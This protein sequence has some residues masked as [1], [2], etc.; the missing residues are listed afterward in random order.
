MLDLM[1]NS[2]WTKT[3]VLRQR[4]VEIISALMERQTWRP[5]EDML[6]ALSDSLEHPQQ[7]EQKCC[8]L[9]SLVSYVVLDLSGSHGNSPRVTPFSRREKS[10]EPSERSSKL[11]ALA[12]PLV[13][14]KIEDKS[15]SVRLKAMQTLGGFIPVIQPDIP[16]SEL[17]YSE[18]GTSPA[19]AS[20]RYNPSIPNINRT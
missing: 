5:S 4:Q 17:P 7:Q 9:L 11:A 16:G 2:C 6:A 8:E 18:A 20:D 19:V 15:D 12:F 14:S 13:L 1:L 10:E 3:P